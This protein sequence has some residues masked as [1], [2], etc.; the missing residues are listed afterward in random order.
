MLPTEDDCDDCV[1]SYMRASRSPTRLLVALLPFITTFFVVAAV[2]LRRLFPLLSGAPTPG[3]KKE[4][5]QK[6]PSRPQVGGGYP[7]QVPQAA[8]TSPFSARRVAAVV[9]ASNIALSAV[10]VELI[11]CEIGNAVDPA[12][13]GLGLR[14]VVGT[15]V[16]SL[17]VVTPAL[18]L[19]SIVRGV[20]FSGTQG[21]GKG[22]AAGWMVEGMGL[23]VWLLGFW[24]LGR[25]A[26][27]S[28]LHEKRDGMEEGHGFR[29]GCLERIGVIGIASMAC[30][31]GFAAV[32]SLWQTFGVRAR[33]VT[34]ADISRKQAGLAA[35]QEMLSAK[36]SRL[37]ALQR[38][39]SD[40]DHQPSGFMTRVIGSIRGNAELQELQTL[41]LEIS[42]LETMATSLSTSL[43]TLQTRRAAQLRA[44]TT[45]G[46]L[47]TL[48]SYLFAFYCLYRIGATSLTTLRRYFLSSSSLSGP[49]QTSFAATDP[50]NN[51]LALIAKH[52]NP[53]LDRAA[54]SRQISFLLSGAMLL[55]AFNSVLQTFLLLARI[56]PSW[57]L[58][59]TQTNLPLIISQICATYVIS[60]ALLLRSN[61][62]REY[63]G[64]VSEA[65][66]A[67]LEGGW[68]ERWFEGWFLGSVVCT[69]VGVWV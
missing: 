49:Q 69:G 32:S 46:H 22:K 55:L 41:R 33:V 64:V 31:A 34:E 4:A 21:K 13:R 66:G 45:L 62:P 52:I 42:G 15:L 8:G 24:Y 14:V 67:R 11:L 18:E 29:E 26:L 65:L 9:F 54:W 16:A 58:A 36:Q 38:R 60:A 68:V 5:Q 35:T 63:R 44:K 28:Y 2:V 10:L 57:L 27:G 59:H 20:G 23:G 53:S 19:H 43:L 6:S 40:S 48:F 47:L 50:I 39:L 25:G 61:L 12:A 51:V 37:R 17:V 1:P 3:S 56:L 30:L 7:P